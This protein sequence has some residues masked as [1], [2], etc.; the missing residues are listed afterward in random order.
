VFF[1]NQEGDL[2]QCQNRAATPYNGTTNTPGFDEAF[3]TAG[4]MASG[5][6]IGTAGGTDNTIWTPVQ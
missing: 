4:D 2:L 1:I 5:L 6:R 3:Q